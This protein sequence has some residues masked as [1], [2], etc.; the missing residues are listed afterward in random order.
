[1]ADSIQEQIVKQMARALAPVGVVQRHN[2]NGVNL[3][4]V[5]TVL[6]KEGEVSAD[7]A[8]SV[9][10]RIRRTMEMFAVVIDRQ[11]DTDPRSG[12]EILNAMTAAAEELIYA[13][14]QWGGLAIQTSP[15]TYLEVEM[16][17]ETPHLARGLRFEV[18]YEHI[19]AN[20]YEQ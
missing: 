7:L 20:P 8:S 1:M 6:L 11:L 4:T 13:N 12:G 17:A 5:P 19:R 16:D 15:P 9:A 10:P 18:M 3:H 2:Q 14:R